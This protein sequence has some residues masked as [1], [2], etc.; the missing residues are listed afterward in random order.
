LTL[1]FALPF[2]AATTAPLLPLLLL[3]GAATGRRATAKDGSEQE[4][5]VAQE[6][7]PKHIVVA[8]VLA[9]AGA[10]AFV[11][12]APGLA[13][14]RALSQLPY[15]PNDEDRARNNDPDRFIPSNRENGPFSFGNAVRSGLESLRPRVATMW[16]PKVETMRPKVETTRPQVETTRRKVETMRPRVQTM[17]PV[18]DRALHDLDV[19]ASHFKNAVEPHLKVRTSRPGVAH[20]EQ[21]HV[22]TYLDHLAK[23]RT[24]R[25]AFNTDA[26][27]RPME[28]VSRPGVAHHEQMTGDPYLDHLAKAAAA[29]HAQ[30][31]QQ[32]APQQGQHAAPQEDPRDFADDM[33]FAYPGGS[34]QVQSGGAP[35]SGQA[36]SAEAIEAA[37]E[38][39]RRAAVVA[40]AE[41]LAPVEA[42]NRFEGRV[43]T[44]RLPASWVRAFKPGTIKYWA[45]AGQPGVE[46]FGFA[47]LAANPEQEVM[48]EQWHA[49]DPAVLRQRIIMHVLHRDGMVPSMIDYFHTR[50]TYLLLE[51]AGTR[52]LDDLLKESRQNWRSSSEPMVP[53]AK[54]LPVMIDLLRS[55]E[56]MERLNMVH[57]ALTER[58]VALLEGDI[59]A[60]L[61]DLRRACMID[62]QMSEVS[63]LTLQGAP[64][65]KLT[66]RFAP[67]MQDGVP[68]GPSNNIWQ[69]G[70]IF[71][72]MLFDAEVP[73]GDLDSSTA[74][75]RAEIEAAIRYN[76]EIRATPGFR[77]LSAE[78]D[79]LRVLVASMLDKDSERRLDASG[80][81]RLASQAAFSRGIAIGPR[82][83]PNPVV[84]ETFH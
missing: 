59:H 36:L 71:A 84:D 2:L 83:S 52:R 7:L 46:L 75:G 65:H 11:P 19:L 28:V 4:A 33:Y 66:Y 34:A 41:G 57:G 51:S 78:Y 69:L 16:P 50:S 37:R 63:Q 76:F 60:L 32:A 18:V 29:Y 68:T 14:G 80:A 6:L 48:F 40:D 10:S 8:P 44:I 30:H 45:R 23:V 38:Q 3:P 64:H 22:D 81:L 82:R 79:D 72:K 54:A 25:N 56:V 53:L 17:R 13:G 62:S 9:A 77:Y 39:A 27:N 1:R 47:R 70:L 67:E 24:T 26:S 20:H 61:P 55:V 31:G 42:S 49:N 21:R 74:E 15:S 35:Y 73:G 5:S 43:D 12:P 58:S